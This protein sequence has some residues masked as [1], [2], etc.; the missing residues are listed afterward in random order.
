[1]I[2]VLFLI[3][4][5]SLSG[6]NTTHLW[7]QTPG[8][9]SQFYNEAE[10]D[11]YI[12]DFRVGARF[13]LDAENIRDT[14]TRTEIVQRYLSYETDN[15]SLRL[16]NFYE[17]LG[18]G[19]ALASFEDKSLR[20]DRN[21]DGGR[22]N[23]ENDY[24]G[25]G[26]MAGRMLEEDHVSRSDWIYAAEVALWPADALDFGA[27]YLRQD[28][29]RD[30]DTLFGRAFE[31]WVEENFTLRVWRFDLIAAAAQRFTWGR[32]SADGWVGVDNIAGLGLTASLS[33]SQQGIGILFEVKD[34]N[35][36]AG[37][38]NAPAPCN[39]DGESINEG[40]D[41]RGYNVA[42]NLAPWNWL[43]IDASYS[44]AWDSTKESTLDR[45]GVE[46]RIDVA[47]HTF[48][49][50]FTWID[51]EIPGASNPQNDMMEAG[52]S[53]ETLIGQVS[54]HTKG[55]YRNVTE[56]AE[57]WNELRPL[58]EVGW[59][60][61]LVSAGG[62][63]KLHDGA[64]SLELWPWGAVRYNAYPWEIM[65]SYGL[66]KGEY[67]CKNGVCAYELPFEGFKADLTLYF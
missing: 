56:A 47:G 23:W 52:L 66:F 15:V 65:F 35:G 50:F 10:A 5:V 26:L 11:L 44:S 6:V 58:L 1:M 40:A 33:Y 53:Y 17:T 14:L 60:E 9:A 13:L 3:G 4:D 62:V 16:G 38:I 54:L 67:I 2:L 8:W 63:A 61:F 21:L 24:L 51:R 43:W 25:V 42:V 41:E 37:G 31:E 19:L 48:I 57:S 46:P 32:Q 36:L 28:A 39:P 30:A 12:D 59:K 20:C 27:V 49:P 55:A 18:Q 22:L 29:T 45:L 7:L 64:D 34:Y